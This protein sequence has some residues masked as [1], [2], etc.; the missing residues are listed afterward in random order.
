MYTSIPSLLNLPP[1]HPHHAIHIGHHRALGWAPCATQQVPTSYVFTHGSVICQSKSFS[2]KPL[3]LLH[4]R[5]DRLKTTIT[6]NKPIWS[7][8]PQPCLS[9]RNYEPCH[10]GPPKM[11]G[12][13]W[14]VL[15]KTRSTAEGNGK[16][17][18]YSCF[19]HPMNSMKMQ[20]DRTLKDELLR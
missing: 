7:Y 2:D 4:Q 16:Q 11:D 17:L 10:V 6:E 18:Q 13:W 9:Q 15:K 3:I 5:A 1:S 14:R 8:G 12:L 20:K 19:E